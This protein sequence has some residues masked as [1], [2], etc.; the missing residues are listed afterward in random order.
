MLTGLRVL[1]A[2]ALWALALTARPEPG[3]GAE[4]P[5][6][7]RAR[8]LRPAFRGDEGIFLLRE[9]GTITGRLLTTSDNGDVVELADGSRTFLPGH[10]ILGLLA[11]EG[12]GVRVVLRD[13]RVVEGRLVEGSGET[14][15]LEAAGARIDLPARAVREARGQEGRLALARGLVDP[16]RGR[17]LWAPTAFALDPGEISLAA[18]PLPSPAVSAGL[19]LGLGLSAG[20]TLPVWYADG[21]G[22]NGTLGAS[23]SLT[24]LPWLR[25]AG[26]IEAYFSSKGDLVSAF[27]ATT[28]GSEDR[29]LSLFAG[30]PPA[31]A[32]RLGGYGRR[33]VSAA[34][35]WR[36]WSSVALLAEAWRGIDGQRHGT[37]G[38]L[39]ARIF[40]QRVALDVGLA[41]SGEGRL[42]PFLSLASTVRAP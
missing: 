3:T 10:S 33:I 38:A 40:A 32:D 12:D 21:L 42:F 24:I 18:G 1:A 15:R 20:T 22:T 23:L 14:V 37:L 30:A 11:P 16:A 29:Y 31:G 39:G 41:A 25:A 13:G 34:A 7:P 35:S 27:A 28:V 6:A 8:E 5:S 26:G 4:A 2:L 19:L 9:G 17:S 36:P